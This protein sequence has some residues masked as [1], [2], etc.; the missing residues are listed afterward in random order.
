MGAALA[1]GGG[2]ALLWSALRADELNRSIRE[3]NEVGGFTPEQKAALDG[4]TLIAHVG[5]GTGVTLVIVGG[6]LVTTGAALLWLG[7]DPDRYRDAAG[8]E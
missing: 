4:D 3:T 6:A 8:H 5:T 7:G 1:A 2:G